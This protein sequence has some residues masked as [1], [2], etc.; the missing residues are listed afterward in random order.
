MVEGIIPEDT[1]REIITLIPVL[2]VDIVI[3]DSRGMYLLVQRVNEPLSRE[4]WV[5]GGRVNKGEKLTEAANRKVKEETGLTVNSLIPVGYFEDFYSRNAF[6]VDGTYHTLSVV[7]KA[8]VD[9]FTDIILDEQ[10]SEWKQED[11]LPDNFVIQ[12]FEPATDLL[13]RIE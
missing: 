7:F 5:V 6:G 8:E 9:S 13:P 11:R 1:Y 10:S 2:C 3:R 12:C 4:W